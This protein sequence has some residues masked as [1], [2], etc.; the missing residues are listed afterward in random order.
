M[1]ER[2]T[3]RQKKSTK[4]TKTTEIVPKITRTNASTATSGGKTPA[5]R[6]RTAK[7]EVSSAAVKRSG[8]TSA[9]KEKAQET[10]EKAVKKAKAKAAAPLVV[11]VEE[12]PIKVE[13]VPA[14]P[15]KASGKKKAAS[16]KH[17]A[18]LKV[19]PLGGLH[20]IG[21]NMTLLECEG[22]ILIIDCGMA[23]P[24]N[25]MLGV[26]VV[27]PDFTYL[28]ENREKIRAVVITHAHEDHIGAIPYFLKEFNV[29][30]YA[31]KLTVGFIK[32]RLKEHNL[33]GDLREIRAG[34]RI[35]AGCFDVEVLHTT[36]SV[37]DSLCFS[38]D[39]PAGRVF[40][41][42]DFK[43]DLTPVDADPIDFGRW[44]QIG[45]E[46]VQLLLADSTNAQRP[47]SS[48]SERLVGESLES[49]FK[50]SN[51]RIIIA[52]FSSNVHRVQKIV[53]LAQ[54]Y[55]RKIAASG[56]S[57]EQMIA[58][59]QELGYMK[60]PAG[61][62]VDIKQVK[63]YPD[64]E[65]VIVT[66]GSQGETM[67]ALARMAAG[68]HKQVKIKAGDVVILSSSPVPGNEK[69]V[70]KV[71]NQLLRLGAQVIYNE[72]ADVHASGHAC[73][74]ELRLIHTI[75]KPKYFM[76]VHG[77]V[78][79][80]MAHSKIAQEIGMSEENI[81]IG[82]NGCVLELGGS[83]EPVLTLE[84][85]TSGNIM[86]D[87]LGVGD[88]GAVV[89]NERR[90]LAEAGLICVT[91]VYDMSSGELLAGPEIHTRGFT[92]VKEYGD[93]LKGTRDATV[94]ALRVADQNNITGIQELRNVCKHA[95][96]KYVA[97]TMDRYPVVLPIVMKI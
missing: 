88:V 19:I 59:A 78:K 1:A 29:P 15:A 46:G 63:D 2:T 30:I 53:N 10:L 54:K 51:A 60:V 32:S 27:I 12:P 81:F 75:L 5:K 71:L 17:N 92:Y 6:R 58:L 4:Q 3:N 90:G 41:T 55:G 87:G 64:S 89:L 72:I 95:V 94:K 25:D 21:K 49:I 68:E 80:L 79:H 31:S 36:H 20:E 82:Q 74:E 67:S 77:E 34:E 86:V 45:K 33:T 38:I 39:T 83:G 96:Q 57:I 84:G 9:V 91:V 35:K 85:V 48:K 23:F 16:K 11:K 76:P 28:R 44:A 69:S 22:D 40:H 66:T 56:R 65:V 52:T 14:A 73:S 13:V 26:D 18:S 43:V 8:R 62:L 93:L 70:N 50:N 24:D 37:A 61:I 97:E 42:G 47:G 7:Q